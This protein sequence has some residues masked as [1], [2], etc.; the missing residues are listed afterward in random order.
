MIGSKM[1]DLRTSRGL[2]LRQLGEQTGLSPTLLSQIERGVTEPSLKSLRLLAGAFDQEVSDLFADDVPLIVHVSRPGERSRITSPKGYI[3]YER[4]A[5]PNGQL[6]VL[7]GV[8]G[9]GEVSSDEPWAHAAIE[10]VYVLSGLLIT[11]VGGVAHPV[12]A[13]EAISF[14]S[15]QPHRYLNTSDDT[16]EFTLSVT[17]PTP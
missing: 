5:A 8:L 1:R 9:P 11:E 10:C 15:S 13:G 3:Q 17:P 4:M 2:S 14:D 7:R 12:A 16:V 6:E